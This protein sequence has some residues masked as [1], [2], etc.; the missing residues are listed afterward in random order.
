MREKL[1]TQDITKRIKITCRKCNKD[2]KFSRIRGRV[3][4]E[5][6]KCGVYFVFSGMAKTTWQSTVKWGRVEKK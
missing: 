3:I 4:F 6:L 2:M 1:Y 5:C